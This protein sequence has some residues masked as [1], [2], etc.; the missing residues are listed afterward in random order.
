MRINLIAVGTRMPAWVE[1]GV[2]E[3]RKR[4]PPELALNIREIALGKRGKNADIAR[5]IAQEGEAMLAAI[6]AR[7]RVVALEVK[8]RAW[9]TE[10]LAQ[11]LAA[12]QMG[13]DDVALLVG[14]LA[15]LVLD[16]GRPDRLIVAMTTYN[17]KSIFAWNIYLYTG[18]VTIVAAYLFVMMDRRIAQSAGPTKVLGWIAF[19]WRLLLTTGTG[20]IFGFLIARDTMSGAVMAPIPVITTRRC[21]HPF[22]GSSQ[23]GG[24]R[25]A[26]TPPSA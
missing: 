8:G 26:Q 1:A 22:M 18:F 20:S 16:L 6:G 5:A 9:S 3:Y 17:F 21:G 13:G 7:D 2:D 14:G 10:Q 12:W 24:S 4:L 15:V 23:S 25:P 19:I 11:Q